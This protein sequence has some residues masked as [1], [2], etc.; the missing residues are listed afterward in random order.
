MADIIANAAGF[1]QPQLTFKSLAARYQSRQ[2]RE[3]KCTTPSK[4]I[5][6]K[7]QIARLKCAVDA[8]YCRINFGT[9]SP[10]M[11]AKDI[12]TILEGLPP[13]R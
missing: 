1:D 13:M 2:D 8:E 4:P 11:W 7:A 5:F 3:W 12:I 9:R 6:P 10:D